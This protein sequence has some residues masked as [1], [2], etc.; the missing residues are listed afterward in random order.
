MD[1][2]YSFPERERQFLTSNS[3][4]DSKVFTQ[5][6]SNDKAKFGTGQHFSKAMYKFYN[7]PWPNLTLVN[8]EWSYS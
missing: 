2:F 1:N 3:S 7:I 8:W 6:S 5:E 4:M